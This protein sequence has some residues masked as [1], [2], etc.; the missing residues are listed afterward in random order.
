MTPQGPRPLPAGN[1]ARGRGEPAVAR[2]P[3]EL[4]PFPTQRPTLERPAGHAKFHADKLHGTLFLTLTV[5][6]AVHISTGHLALG[7]DV[8][9]KGIP[10]LKT[11]T[12]T[13]NGRLKIQ[14]SSLKGAIRAMYEAIT[15]STLAVMM[16]QYRNRIPPERHPCRNKEQLCPASR[17]FGALNWQGL[18]EFRDAIATGTGSGVGSLP[19]LYRPR[20]DQCKAYFKKENG[21][22]IGRKFYYTHKKA[23]QGSSRGTPTQQAMQNTVFKTQI[24]FKN[25]TPAELGT[26]LTVLGQDPNH[27]MLLKV[28]GGK[29]VGLGS[30]QVTLDK[31]ERPGNLKDR[32]SRY[33]P[34]Q[35]DTLEGEALKA[36]VQKQIQAA[37]GY[38]LPEQLKRLA[39]I[40]SPTA[41]REPPPGVY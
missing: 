20:P 22:V 9:V 2:K 33:D 14:G 29:P 37:Q 24:H 5:Q 6:T 26:L 23:L 10:V 30:L 34:P 21:K 3:Y 32:Y 11:M 4:I 40:L 25:L 35:A 39:A 41:L 18:V 31:I 19:P 15:N 13:P 16:S 12:T 17:V 28:G 38:I 36:F 8:G 1:P 27:P 7:S